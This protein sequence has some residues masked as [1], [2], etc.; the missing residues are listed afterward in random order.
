MSSFLYRLGRLAAKR[1]RSVLAVW[2]VV[3]ALACG[4]G[5][6]IGS[7]IAVTGVV[8]LAVWLVAGALAT[9]LVTEQRRVLSGKQ[10]RLGTVPSPAT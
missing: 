4:G 3:L 8:Q 10:L 9:V 6:F 7:D 2:L 1:R 5:L